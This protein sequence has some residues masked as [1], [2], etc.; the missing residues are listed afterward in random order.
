MLSTFGSFRLIALIVFGLIFILVLGVSIF[1]TVKILSRTRKDSQSPR[2]TVEATVVTKRL[3]VHS[4]LSIYFVTFQQESGER[5]ELHM[6][7]NDYDMLTEGEIG[8]LT[9]QGTQ[10]LSFEKI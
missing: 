7:S 5:L 2:I 10:F 3:K 4:D 8:T 6:H 1:V 9:Y